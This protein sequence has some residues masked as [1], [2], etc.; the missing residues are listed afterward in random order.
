[1][2]DPASESQKWKERYL[3]SLDELE[4]SKKLFE[5]ELDTLKKALVRVSLAADGVDGRLDGYL[6]SLRDSVRKNDEVQ[7]IERVIAKIE[8]LLRELDEGRKESQDSTQEV[9]NKMVQNLAG[10]GVNRAIKKKIK[11]FEKEVRELI[12]NS[13]NHGH[14]VQQYLLIQEEV[15][16]QLETGKEK[17]EGFWKKLVKSESETE[18]VANNSLPVEDDELEICD[19]DDIG[20]PNSSSQ[21]ALMAEYEAVKERV[22]GV[23]VAFLDQ[24]EIPSY[25]NSREEKVRHLL[26]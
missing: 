6:S 22:S 3:A 26:K 12:D 4:D 14:L 21:Q 24:L 19:D 11:Q 16:D 25:L 10:V 9:F 8:R 15:L 1:M 17:K 2:S 7:D 13:D 5:S 20:V 23:L 18:S